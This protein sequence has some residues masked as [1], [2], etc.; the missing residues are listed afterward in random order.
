MTLSIK[1]SERETFG[2]VN[3]ESKSGKDIQKSDVVKSPLRRPEIK[4]G[5]RPDRKTRRRINDAHPMHY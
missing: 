4:I 2:A 3:P 5:L 1:L